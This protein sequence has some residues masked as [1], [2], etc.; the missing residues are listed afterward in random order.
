L[1]KCPKESKLLGLGKMFKRIKELRF[2]NV[3]SKPTKELS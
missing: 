1:G 3:L 2:E